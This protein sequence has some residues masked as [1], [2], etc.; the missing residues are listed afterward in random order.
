MCLSLP[1]YTFDMS[2]N[3]QVI[4]A[5]GAKLNLYVEKSTSISGSGIVNVSGNPEVKR[6]GWAVVFALAKTSAACSAATLRSRND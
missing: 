1:L 4:L 3:A 2:G 5:P 6:D